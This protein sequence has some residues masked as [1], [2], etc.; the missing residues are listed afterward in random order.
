MRSPLLLILV[1]FIFIVGCGSDDEVLVC[2]PTPSTLTTVDLIFKAQFGSEP[3]V[4]NT[5][6]YDYEGMGMTISKFDFYISDVSLFKNIGGATEQTDILDIE[7]VDFTQN[8]NLV[9]L[10][11][12]EVPLGSYDGIVFS[13]GVPSDLNGQQPGDF[14]VTHPLGIINVGHHWAAWDS[15]IF[16]K[17]E[18]RLDTTGNQDFTNFSYHPGTNELFSGP[19]EKNA[20]I[21]LIAN[22]SNTINFEVDL[23]NIFINGGSLDIQSFPDSHNPDE[24]TGAIHVMD[25][26]PSAISIN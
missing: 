4:F 20:S 21:E 26:F 6:T 12:T 18:G 2:E 24:A 16:S 23:E 22:N 11:L 9:T 13:I 5:T 14:S 7:F 10:E 19:I 8:N 25:N 3:L 1:L 17:I 15:Y